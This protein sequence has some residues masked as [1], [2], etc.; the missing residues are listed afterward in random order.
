MNNQGNAPHDNKYLIPHL[1]GN[2]AR[3]V[4]YDNMEYNAEYY[5]QRNYAKVDTAYGNTEDLREVHESEFES[6]L[7]AE[8]I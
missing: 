3:L 8:T 5:W 4:K 7:D 6:P 2:N 1:A